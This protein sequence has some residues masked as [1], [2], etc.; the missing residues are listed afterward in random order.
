MG[1]QYI[2][3]NMLDII[4]IGEDKY[5]VI[6]KI[7]DIDKDLIEKISSKY[8]EIYTDFILIKST[9]N[10]T[11]PEHYLFCRRVDDIDI[12]SPELTQ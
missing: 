8:K 7:Y 2:G 5:E 12:I 9:E 3:K 6:R 1:N 11:I 10:P 4:C